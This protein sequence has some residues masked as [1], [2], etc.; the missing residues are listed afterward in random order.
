MR[1]SLIRSLQRTVQDFL[2]SVR[3]IQKYDRSTPKVGDGIESHDG[4]GALTDDW[5]DTVILIDG[6]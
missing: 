1:T 6:V 3:E 4:D 5:S 2:Q